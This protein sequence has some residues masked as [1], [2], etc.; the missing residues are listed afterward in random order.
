MDPEIIQRLDNK[1][2]YRDMSEDYYSDED[3]DEV[4][5]GAVSNISWPSTTP[6]PMIG[7]LS[8]YLNLKAAVWSLIIG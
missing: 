4:D 2:R 1:F 7:S 6:T 8:A 3:G 5:L